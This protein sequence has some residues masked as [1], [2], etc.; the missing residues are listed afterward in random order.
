MQ[1]E[2][3]IENQILHWLNW[4]GYFA[5]KT[6]TTAN[7]DPKVGCYIKTS[8]LYRK[9][10]ADI[11]GLF[12]DGTLFAIEVKAEKGVLA[13]HQK[14]FLSEIKC[15]N[16]LAIVARSVE[17]VEFK[18]KVFLGERDARDSANAGESSAR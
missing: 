5:W 9:G 6:K 7:Y 11:I 12:D 1:R 13:S 14:L 3:V 17:E 16:A 15:R 10:V 2:R 8:K 18:F 4:K